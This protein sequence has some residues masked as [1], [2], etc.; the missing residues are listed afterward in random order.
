MA[1]SD[2]NK[3]AIIERRGLN[4]LITLSNRLHDDPSVI[5]EVMTIISTLCLRSPDHAAMAMEAGAGELA[6]QAMKKFPEASQLQKYSCLMIRNLVARNTE[7]RWI[8]IIIFS[9]NQNLEII[10]F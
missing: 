3:S 2:F 8:V 1:G 7:N 10:S 9:F 4:R 6:I 5:Q